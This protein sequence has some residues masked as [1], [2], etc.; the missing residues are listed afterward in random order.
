[1]SDKIQNTW[2]DTVSDNE[3]QASV[4]CGAKCATACFRRAT[5][6]LVVQTVRHNNKVQCA[7]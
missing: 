4:L 2:L 5:F 6:L 3:Y 7:S 1:M